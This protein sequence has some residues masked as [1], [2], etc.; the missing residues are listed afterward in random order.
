LRQ[1]RTFVNKFLFFRFLFRDEPVES[2][3][4]IPLI[5]SRE[6][7]HGGVEKMQVAFL[8]RAISRRTS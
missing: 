3:Y 5:V 8:T 4:L 6:P 2:S 1:N 7:N